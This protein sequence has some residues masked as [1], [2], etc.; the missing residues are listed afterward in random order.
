MTKRIYVRFEVLTAVVMKNSIFWDIT[1]S[2]PLKIN[3]RF[4]G[5]CLHFQGRRI[6][7]VRNQCESSGTTCHLLSTLFLELAHSLTMKMETKYSSETSV[8]LS[9]NYTAL[10]PRR[11]SSQEYIYLLLFYDTV[12]VF[13]YIASY[14][15]ITAE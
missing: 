10:Y 11:Y 13:Y 15:I 9:M 6:I 8:Q 2:N 7:Q 12:S 4:G 3:R 1:P 5:T 14:G